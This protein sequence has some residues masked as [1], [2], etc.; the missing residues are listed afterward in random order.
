MDIRIDISDM[1]LDPES[2]KDRRPETGRVLD[3]LWSGTGMN[4][5]VQ[6]PLHQEKE[7]L[8][9]ILNVADILKQETELMVVIGVENAVLPAEAAVSAL[10][11]TLDGIEIRFTGQNFCTSALSELMREMSRRDTVLCVI[12]KTGEE[13]EVQAAFSV[14]RALMVRKYGSREHAA[15]RTVVITEQGSALYREAQNEGYLTF[16]Y[17]EDVS[18][19]YGALTPAGLLPMAAAGIDIRD[20]IS[21]AGTMAASPEWDSDGADYAIARV[22]VRQ[23]CNIE[24][25]STFDSRFEGICRWM[26]RLYESGGAE[27]MMTIAGGY[28][29]DPGTGN[30]F[31]TIVS[32]EDCGDDIIIPDGA[33]AGRRLE[34]FNREKFMH[35]M[36]TFAESGRYAAH[37]CLPE[38]D[39]FH[40]GQLVYFLQTNCQIASAL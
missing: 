8:D 5:W 3:R 27:G 14:L 33:F 7:E 40:Y 18:E 34:D 11:N 28:N 38:A 23:N 19:L 37:L 36:Q 13:P 26:K 10:P 22:L 29:E 32:A 20:F 4:G 31:E 16:I 2:I 1:K 9:Y 35:T 39:P 6:A 21:G 17:P 30:V 12:S 25:I 15:R 24:R